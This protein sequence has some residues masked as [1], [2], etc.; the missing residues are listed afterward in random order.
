MKTLLQVSVWITGILAALSTMVIFVNNP[1]A[2]ALW[3][4][5]FNPFLFAFLILLAIQKQKKNDVEN[6][7]LDP[8]GIK[9]GKEALQQSKKD[10]ASLESRD[11][12]DKEV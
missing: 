6:S 11:Q 1:L 5:V 10:L 12:G 9:R 3:R 7:Q 2:T 8:E 4:A